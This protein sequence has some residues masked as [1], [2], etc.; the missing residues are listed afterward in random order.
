MG[1][2][3]NPGNAGFE[4]AVHSDIYIDKTELTGFT[5]A[6]LGTKQKFVCVSRPRRFG[7]SMAAE[8]LTAYYSRGCDS[9][10][11]FC[12]CK[13][14]SL[15]AFEK[16]LNAYNVVYMDIQWFYSIAKDKGIGENTISY[17]QHE[18]IRE[19]QDQYQELLAETE[20]SLSEVLLK[21]YSKTGEQFV[22]IID[23]WD[24]LF[25]E[26]KDNIR[27]QETY[28]NFLRGLFKGSL[29]ES[30]ICLAYITGILPIKKYGTQSALNN[31]DEY[32]MVSPKALAKYV[33][34]TEE[35]VHALCAEHDV[36]FEEVKSWYD[37]YSLNKIES[38]YSPNSVIKAISNQEM[39]S[40]WTETETYEDLKTYINM[41]FD[42][43]KETIIQMLGGVR[44]KI[45]TRKFQNDMTSI[46]SRDDVMTLL[47]HLGY[48]AYD[49]HTQEVYIPNQEVS[50]EFL[51]VIEDGGWDEIAS[52]LKAS[53]MLL[54][55]TIQGN[56]KAVAASIDRIHEENISVLE[57]N[58]EL[59]LSCVI[60]LA[61]FSAGKDYVLVRELPSGKGFA[62][63]AF[64]PRKN[65]D[66]PALIVELK[67]DQ[68]AQAA[69]GQIK[70]K[71]YTGVL[72]EYENNLLLVGINYNKNTRKHEC[73]IEKFL[74]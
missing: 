12:N 17:M 52:T 39:G 5:N 22:V 29:A 49:G 15:A 59:S 6:V 14:A 55:D 42:G 44:C 43:L 20:A 38:V 66:K 30:S 50:D 70:S 41:D 16:H 21:I 37:G 68:S 11:L 69:I 64:I 73:I 53:E 19:L 58:S 54:Y 25:R 36:D 34:F 8:M 18:V 13:A 62:D 45:N 24:C 3:L 63:V 65:S 40:Y 23:E 51:N 31:F 1:M 27:L 57:Y 60:T 56:E 7:K 10:M 71:N 74:C 61:Y 26:A 72:R 33:G 4:S 47:V 28:I 67:W 46:K 9:R 48:L 32:T 35:E 2:F